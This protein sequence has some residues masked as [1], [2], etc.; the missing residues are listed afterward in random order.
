MLPSP[1][2]LSI[3]LA[4][5]SAYTLQLAKVLLAD[6]RFQITGVVTPT[7]QPVGRQKTLTPSPVQIWAEAE[8]IPVLLIPEKI[9]Q[10]VK[11]EIVEHNSKVKCDFLLVVDFGYFVPNW[12]LALPQIGPVNVHPSWL[13]R[14]RGSSPAQRVLL[15]GE[16]ESAVSVIMMTD[17]LDAGDLVAQL[18]FSVQ[19]NWNS[20]A[21]YEFAFNLLAPQ[22]GNILGDLAAGTVTLR[23][24]PP[25]SP[26]P[27][28]ARLSKTDS[29]VPW[30]W[31]AE[32]CGWTA[33]EPGE[34]PAQAP[35]TGLLQDLA[36]D[37]NSGERAQLFARASR[38]FSPWPKLWTLLP[39]PKGWQRL[40]IW[41]ADF[42][43]PTQK[44]KLIQV[45]IEGKQPSSWN[46]IKNNWLQA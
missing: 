17:Q 5:S 16:T 29:Y 35:Q 18:P 10:N 3:L 37:M 15:A 9:D 27:M 20:Q 28:A 4:G 2:P 12:L 32:T 30:H 25:D 36:S 40:I 46:E 26:T 42:D 22:L 24:Q 8:K 39:T 43:E 44:L 31:L 41:Q 11:K 23:A 14:W 34:A 45:Q 1:A 13:P 19:P 21:Y 33:Q 6:P 7:P 38:A